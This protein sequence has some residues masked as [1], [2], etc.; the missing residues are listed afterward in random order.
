MQE[1]E[2]NAMNMDVSEPNEHSGML[3]ESVA[4]GREYLSRPAKRARHIVDSE[5]DSE[6]YDDDDDDDYGVI[7]GS[8]L[9]T[10][11]SIKRSESSS[12]NLQHRTATL[13]TSPKLEDSCSCTVN[14]HECVKERCNKQKLCLVCLSAKL[15]EDR[16]TVDRL[17]IMTSTAFPD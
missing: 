12:L 15:D 1:F 17:A 3:S 4:R 7:S 11:V 14:G 10:G 16:L 8:S 13:V 5:S 6:D 9:E 2:N